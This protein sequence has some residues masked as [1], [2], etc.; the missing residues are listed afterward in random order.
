MHPACLNKDQN[1][2]Q[3]SLLRQTQFWVRKTFSKPASLK[4]ASVVAF[5]VAISH[6]VS[7]ETNKILRFFNPDAKKLFKPNTVPKMVPSAQL[8]VVKEEE[9][10]SSHFWDRLAVPKNE[11]AKS[12]KQQRPTRPNKN[13]NCVYLSKKQTR[14]VPTASP[15]VC[16]FRCHKRT[17]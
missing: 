1:H 4:R 2:L 12:Q 5:P 10:F 17:L 8:T 13:Y 9:V 15:K 16:D 6:K 7:V 3:N 11:T 14:E